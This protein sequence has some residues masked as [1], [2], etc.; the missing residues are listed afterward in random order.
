M[1]CCQGDLKMRLTIETNE[2]EEESGKFM[3]AARLDDGDD[4][5]IHI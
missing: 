3:L 4:N 2:E 1:G 5:D